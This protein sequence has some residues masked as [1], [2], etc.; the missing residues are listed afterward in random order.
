MH[1]AVNTSSLKSAVISALSNTR[2]LKALATENP[3]FAG[4]TI[5][6]LVALALMKLPFILKVAALFAV[7]AGGVAI[8]LNASRTEAVVMPDHSGQS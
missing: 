8:G 5:L 7:I 6:A 3:V 1:H 2:R 4:I